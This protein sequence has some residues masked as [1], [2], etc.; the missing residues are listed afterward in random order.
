[1]K[2]LLNIRFSQL[3]NRE[4][5]EMLSYLVSEGV[6][7]GILAKVEEL[8]FEP[9]L[10]SELKEQFSE[11]TY[12]VLANY[13]FESAKLT[14]N[15]LQFEAGFGED[16]MGSVVS[17]PLLSIVQ[18]L[19]GNNPILINVAQKIEIKELTPEK[20]DRREKSKNIFLSNPENSF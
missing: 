14:K 4:I 8:K 20:K 10:P 16:N 7:F 18:I 9:E 3:M 17:V 1:M 19:I 15:T 13:T 11:I 6:D 2:R 12:F 5:Y